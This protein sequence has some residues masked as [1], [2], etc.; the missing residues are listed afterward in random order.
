MQT[1]EG[2]YRNGRVELREKPPRIRT[3]R[4]IVTFLEDETDAPDSRQSVVNLGEIL[5]DDLESA[6][7]EIAAVFNQA[8]TK[9]ALELEN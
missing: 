9:S 8:V 6:S 1:I 3:A 4:V 5:D 7:R 2:I